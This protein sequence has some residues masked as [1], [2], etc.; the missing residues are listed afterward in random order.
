MV[1]VG[2][3]LWQVEKLRDEFSDVGHVVLGG[4]APGVL[5]AV[6]HP[7]CKIEMAALPE[8]PWELP[9]SVRKLQGGRILEN[10]ISTLIT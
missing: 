8:T 3:E 10:R 4:R 1:S 9:V 2:E 6:E 7:V 5:H